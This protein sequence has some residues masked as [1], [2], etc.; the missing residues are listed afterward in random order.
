VEFPVPDPDPEPDP[1]LADPGPL[2]LFPATVGPLLQPARMIARHR[3][4]V[5]QRS[6]Q[7][8]LHLIGIVLLFF[9]NVTRARKR[10]SANEATELGQVRE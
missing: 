4:N 8:E 1:E 3:K 2:P 10:M 5:Q 6:A 7:G 9:S